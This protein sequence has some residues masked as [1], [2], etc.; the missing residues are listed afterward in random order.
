LKPLSILLLGNSC[1][2]DKSIDKVRLSIASQL[3]PDVGQLESLHQC[4]QLL[5]L[6]KV[7]LDLSCALSSRRSRGRNADIAMASLYEGVAMR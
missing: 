7:I 3:A 4:V 2:F 5:K 1:P 6:L